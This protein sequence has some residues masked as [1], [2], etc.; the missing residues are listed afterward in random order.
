LIAAPRARVRMGRGGLHTM[1]NF[2]CFALV[3]TLAL[4]GSCGGSEPPS[5]AATTADAPERRF[6][7]V[8]G[9]RIIAEQT[10]GDNWLSHGR[11]YD[12][13][14]F[15]PLTQIDKSNVARLGLAWYADFETQRNQQSTPLVVDGVIYVTETWDKV[16][17][18]D[19]RTGER[20]WL[21]DPKVPGE[22]LVNTCC[23]AVNR[24]V[25]VWQGKVFV[26][27]AD[28]R[29][30]AIDAQ[31]G[32]EVWSVPT[33]PRGEPYA[34]TGAPRVAKGKVFIGN[35]GAEFGVRGFV[36]AYDV[37]TGNRDWIWYT[38]PGNPA[39]GFEN[40]QM[41]EA[42]KTWNGEW[43]RTGGGGTVWDGITYDPVTDLLLI[44]TGNGSPWPSEIRSP[45]GGDNLYLCS[46]VA[47]DPDSGEYVW[48]YQT[49]PADS[50]DYN[51]AQQIIIA[52]LEIDGRMR[53]VA[54]QAPKNGFFYVLDVATGE[55]ISAEPVVPVTWAS[56]IDMTTGRP[57]ENPAAR[58]DK[59]GKGMVVT[60]WFNGTHA[61]HPM[62][63]N[64]NTGLVY[65]PIE[66]RNYG[67]ITTRTDD[68]PMGMRLSI[69][70]VEGPKLH[71]TLGIPLIHETFLLAWDPVQKREVFRVPHGRALSGG[72][73]TTAT[74]LVFQ[75]N[76]NDNAF[77]AF[78]AENGELLWSY[79]VQ[80]GALAGPVTFRVD[81]EQ[82]VAVVGGYR[83]TRSYYEP[84]GS[85]LLVF[86]LGGTARLPEPAEFPAPVLAPPENFGTGAEL[87]AGERTYDTYC[88]AC[89][90]VDGQSRVFFPDLRYTPALTSQELF[91]AIVLD[92]VRSAKGMVS[93]AQA[94]T[95]EDTVALRAYLTGQANELKAANATN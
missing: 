86:K 67:F 83:N 43:W 7:E 48:H 56:G 13:Q 74:N 46:I 84:N 75:G 70:L 23:D 14:R 11:T 87:A 4:L 57:I 92:G 72:T 42:A 24:G 37:D 15:S 5:A 51:S 36:A 26:G 35:G 1:N 6:G 73:V 81:D 32:T 77:K 18:Y 78:A 31:T 17:A 65:V 66:H 80:T 30:I 61:W 3:S 64:P 52:D 94:L 12:E 47:L 76:R 34:I 90:G 41:A 49:V 71:D 53:H 22:W 62:S 29:L 59:T 89:H 55:L 40:P 79:D 39:N 27:T 91:D 69:S 21:F 2:R 85:R 10:T 95:R 19:A 54:M 28:N 16:H 44:G 20:L 68:N 45:G 88:V 60:P 63:Y 38:V 93:F 8:D 9:A 82:Y 50:W 25:A 58:F 33:T